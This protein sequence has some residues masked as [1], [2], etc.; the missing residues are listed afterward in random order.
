VL[1]HAKHNLGVFFASQKTGLAGAP[2]GNLRWP[3]PS[4]PSYDYCQE[5]GRLPVKPLSLIRCFVTAQPLHKPLA[6]H[7]RVE[8]PPRYQQPHQPPRFSFSPSVRSSRETSPTAVPPPHSAAAMTATPP[9]PPP[10]ADGITPSLCARTGPYPR[11]SPAGAQAPRSLPPPRACRTCSC[12]RHMLEKPKL[13]PCPRRAP[14][15]HKGP[16][17]GF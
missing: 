4:N 14:A 11:S 1:L 16:A 7:V 9:K 17:H 2:H 6:A 3:R 12:P 10:S 13:C 8:L 5:A 15:G